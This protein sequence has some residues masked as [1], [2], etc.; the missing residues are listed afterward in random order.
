[1]NRRADRVLLTISFVALAQ[2]GGAVV[3]GEA[4]QPDALR[5][6][7]ARVCITPEKPIWLHGYAGKSRFRP[8]EGKLNDL[9][10]KAM[11]WRTLTENGRC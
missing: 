4:T 1:M 9:F 11:A 10:A 7:L 2:L 5:V 6:G 3:R 8:F